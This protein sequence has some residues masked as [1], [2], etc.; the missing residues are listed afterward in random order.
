MALGVS[1]AV[2]SAA[3]MLNAGCASAA[4]AEGPLTLSEAQRRA[5][6]RS[7]LVVAQDASVTASR[8]MA[9]A[10]SQLPDP[11]GKVGINNLPVNGPDAFSL[12]RDFMTM[13]SIGVMQEFTRAEKR[14]AKSQRFEREAEQSL[15]QKI[16]TVTAIQRDTA[17]AW[18]DRY[19]ADAMLNVLGEERTSAAAEIE[20][21]ESS[22][23][24]GRGALADVLTARSALVA[25]DDRGSELRRRVRTAS[26]ALARWIGEGADAPLGDAPQM[27]SIPIEPA[28][29]ESDVAHHPDLA[30]LARKEDVAAAEVR[31]AQANK[32]TDWSV[33]VMYSQRGPSFSNMV[34]VNV[35]VPLQWDRPNRQDREV[36][37]RIAMLDQARA[38][39]NDMLRAH[40][41]EIRSMIEEWE[42]GR[43]RLAR[44]RQEMLPLAGERTQA[45]LGGYRGARNGLGDVLMARR[46]EVDVRLQALQLELE[47]ARLWAQLTFIYPA[48][49]RHA[50]SVPRRETP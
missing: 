38:E 22:Y 1:L 24:A 5:V 48:D 47:T 45:L 44:Y 40:V 15:A 19:Y 36:A 35:S 6:E 18:L 27:D 26:V 17:L 7:Q 9:V 10:A 37:A 21:A 20:A 33:E 46:N 11:V 49:A 34:S 8:E 28:T 29:L 3:F 25:L 23:R 14:E 30:V 2:L 31:V 42:S 4:A 39:R 13:R 43:E 12:T 41:A 50:V 16:V 32:K